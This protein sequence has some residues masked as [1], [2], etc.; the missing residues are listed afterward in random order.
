MLQKS[1]LS[2]SAHSVRQAHIYRY[3]FKNIWEK[4]NRCHI[5]ALP[6]QGSQVPADAHSEV[7]PASTAWKKMGTAQAGTT[8]AAT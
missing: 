6:T 2:V 5:P 7:I 1:A 8:N 4:G 3:A